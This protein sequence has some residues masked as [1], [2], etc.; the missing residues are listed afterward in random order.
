MHRVSAF[1]IDLEGKGVVNMNLIFLDTD[2][3]GFV[4]GMH[5]HRMTQ[6]LQG[7]KRVSRTKRN[8]PNKP[9]FHDAG[10][11]DDLHTNIRPEIPRE[12]S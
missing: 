9:Q 8:T 3:K 10:L 7:L 5:G 4:A 6:P 1:V 12:C 2:S 11:V